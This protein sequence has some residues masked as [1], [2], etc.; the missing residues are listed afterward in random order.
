M[1]LMN[2]DIRGER[3]TRYSDIINLLEAEAEKYRAQNL[4]ER[5]RA[6]ETFKKGL[7][8]SKRT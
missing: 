5:A 3:Y 1:I 2:Y 8:L 4:P 7:E 6:L